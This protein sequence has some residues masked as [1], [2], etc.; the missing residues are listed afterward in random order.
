MADADLLIRN[1]RLF[2]PHLAPGEAD[3]VAVAG[4][5]ILAVGRSDRLAALAGPRTRTIDAAG[6]SLLPAFVEA[7][8]HLFGGAY[9]R[10]LLQLG[11]VQG[12]EA[13]RDAV[14]AFAAA[15]P[16]EGLLIG[17]GASYGIFGPEVR[18]D[19]FRLDAL[20][21]VR[22]L[23]LYAYDFHTA[24]AN[25]AALRA[26]GLLGGRALGPGNE[27]VTGADGTATGELR[28]KLA[29]LP[30]MALRTSGGRE[31]L[32]MSGRDPEPPATTAERRS[33]IEV[34]KEGLRHCAAQGIAQIH[35]MDGNRYQLELLR[36]IE[37]EEGALPC[38][39]QIPFHLT[40]DMGLDALEEASALDAEHRGDMLRS[41][42]VKI[43]IDGV[44]ESG[45]AVL[46][47]D[48]ADRPGWRGEPLFD[49]PAFRA[50]AVEIDRRGLQ[51]SV[52]AIGDGAV[53][54]ALDGYAAARDAN[55][56]RD[57]R[58]RIEH[59][60]TIRP[61]D[62]PRFAALGVVASPQPPHAPGTS[63]APFGREIEAIGP[64]RWPT[65]YAW[66]AL[67]D[68]GAPICFSSD[69]PVSA[70]EPLRGIEAAMT[71]RT[72][73]E[74]LPD[75]RLS[76]S[77]TLAAYTSGGAYAGFMEDR[78]GRIAEGF[79]ADLTLLSG[80]V[81]ATPYGEIGALRPVLTLCDGRVTHDAAA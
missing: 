46:L 58:H 49:G 59:I 9:G 17:Q 27:V 32:G 30:V 81:E 41:G 79:L 5:R 56:A 25:T 74:G 64:A 73:A 7:H 72:W 44:L 45:T 10:R 78:T 13:A 24:W 69:W 8:M 29:F 21:P 60:E 33:D 70:L 50:A 51:I 11:G 19:R 15:N 39:V 47:D 68:A 54:I 12:F 52:H 34:L 4:N 62:I 63:G 3:A 40:A 76:L 2:A 22:P 38:R 80:D 16:A 23:I 36:E 14:R 31:M 42:R 55:G 53:R 61:E 65:A 35:N 18:P 77:E 26:A 67:A 71:R 28:E 66:R 48:Y 37:R 75:Q 1:A 20:E 43:F 6:A 57:S